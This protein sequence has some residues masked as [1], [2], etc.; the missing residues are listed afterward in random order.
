MI[1]ILTFVESCRI[2][3]TSDKILEIFRLQFSSSSRV[4]NNY[5]VRYKDLRQISLVR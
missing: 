2:N 4:Y 5:N 1:I 3:V